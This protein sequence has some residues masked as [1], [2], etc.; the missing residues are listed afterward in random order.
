M[1]KSIQDDSFVAYTMTIVSR[2]HRT[3]AFPVIRPLDREQALVP[4]SA[5]NSSNNWNIIFFFK[6][7]IFHISNGIPTQAISTGLVVYGFACR[8]LHCMC[9]EHIDTILFLHH[10][11]ILVNSVI[12]SLPQPRKNLP[13]RTS[14]LPINIRFYNRSNIR[15]HR[16][17]KTILLSTSRL[18]SR[19]FITNIS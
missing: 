16:R 8:L 2:F 1:Y 17:I 18:I 14:Y 6:N 11:C 9:N 19:M 10:Y 3:W 12:K 15:I 4:T 5:S 7:L 13:L